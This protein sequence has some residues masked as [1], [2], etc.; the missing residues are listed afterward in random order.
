MERARLSEWSSRAENSVSKRYIQLSVWTG[1]TGAGDVLTCQWPGIQ[2]NAKEVP[3]DAETVAHPL[4][5]DAATYSRI[6]CWM[7]LAAAAVSV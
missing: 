5:G 2:N 7:Q 4:D 1:I 6:G 3:E